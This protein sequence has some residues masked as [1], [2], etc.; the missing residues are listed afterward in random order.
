[1]DW[2]GRSPFGV[3]GGVMIGRIHMSLHWGSCRV[4][5]GFTA[6]PAPPS[7]LGEL[8]STSHPEA[9]VSGVPH[10]SPFLPGTLLQGHR[11]RKNRPVGFWFSSSGPSIS[12][13]DNM[14]PALGPQFPLQASSVL[15]PL[16]GQMPWDRTGEGVRCGKNTC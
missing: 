11:W 8:F 5:G 9:A 2:V 4:L 6:G 10:L 13:C 16:L 12:E 7:S 15:L 14:A 3:S 1:M